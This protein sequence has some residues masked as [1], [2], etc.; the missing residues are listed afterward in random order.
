MKVGFKCIKCGKVTEFETKD[1]DHVFE[2]EHKAPIFT[3]YCVYCGTK[4]NTLLDMA[5]ADKKAKAGT[6]SKDTKVVKEG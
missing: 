2:E 3:V 5:K 1:A 6:G 4:N